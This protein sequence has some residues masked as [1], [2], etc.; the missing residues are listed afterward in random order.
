[1]ILIPSIIHTLVS[2]PKFMDPSYD[3]SSL[4]TAHSGA[5]FLPPSLSAKFRDKINV[6]SVGSGYGLSECTI[7][8]LFSVVE[9]LLPDRIKLSPGSSGFLYPSM[10]ARIVLTNG[11]DAGVNETGELWL[12]GTNIAMGYYNDEKATKDAFL[13][14]GWL[15]TGDHFR[16]DEN[17][18]FFFS[19]R[20]KDTLKVSGMQVSPQEIEEFI[21]QG[22]ATQDIVADVAVAGVM[23]AASSRT[24]DEKVPRAWVVMT[25]KG[26]K[27]GAKEVAK[28]VKKAVEEGLSRYKWLRG[29][30]E[31]VSAIPK[32]PTGKVLKRQLVSE[33][34]KKH[35]IHRTKL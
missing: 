8:G 32:N 6:P 5:A 21:F 10:K 33:Y 35:K 3:T 25:P 9:G 24:E 17:K 2:S 34:D 15:R 22:P 7:A 1:M 13:P 4:L 23:T 28:V 27:L 26:K 29:G 19:D 30:V 16:V 14:D 31:V 11:Q 20:V 18:N 12:Y